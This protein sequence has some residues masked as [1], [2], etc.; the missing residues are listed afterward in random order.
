MKW[1]TATKCYNSFALVHIRSYSFSF[2]RP[3]PH[4]QQATAILG[5]WKQKHILIQLSFVGLAWS[6]TPFFEFQYTVVVALPSPKEESSSWNDGY[7]FCK[8]LAFLNLGLTR[9]FS[10]YDNWKHVSLHF[11]FCILY[12]YNYI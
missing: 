10:K 5:T 2:Q 6:F 4:H 12:L 7:H 1:R 8:L 11:M 9:K 3:S